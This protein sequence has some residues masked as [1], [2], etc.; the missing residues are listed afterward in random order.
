MSLRTSLWTSLSSYNEM[1]KKWTEDP[2]VTV[3]VEAVAKEL[4]AFQKQAFVADKALGDGVSALFKSKVLEF[5]QYSGVVTDLGNRNMK[6]R[7]WKK[8]YRDIGQP[9]EPNHD[10]RRTLAELMAL[11]VFDFPDAVAECSARLKEKKGM[12][13]G[14]WFGANWIVIV[15]F[16]ERRG[17]SMPAS[18][19]CT[20]R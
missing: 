8:L 15:P 14:V 19:T 4:A 5:K 1:Y 17:P 6:E 20:V 3:D 12:F 10:A 18:V 2:F 7:H 16:V 9:F 11:R 13:G